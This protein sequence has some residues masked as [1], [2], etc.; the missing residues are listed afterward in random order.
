MLPSH[1]LC[2]EP[3]PHGRMTTTTKAETFRGTTG[4]AAAP[5]FQAGGQSGG[6]PL[7][8]ANP[9]KQT[10]FSQWESAILDG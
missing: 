4:V 6:F 8:L 3:A 1:R 10:G 2:S 9:Q 5:V 7:G